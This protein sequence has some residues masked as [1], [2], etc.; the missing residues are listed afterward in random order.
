MTAVRFEP[1]GPLRGALRPPPDKSIS[2]RA[3][4]IGAMAEGPTRITGYLDSAD[5]RATLRAVE[6]L[7]AEVREGEPDDHGG[8]F[9]EI[10]G[11]GL[12][13]AAPGRDRRRQRRDAAAAAARV[14]RRAGRRASGRSTAT[15]RSGAGRSTGSPSRC[16]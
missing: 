2:H 4:L 15:T 12:R 14:A 9:V 8:I 13:G 16:G 3:A 5:T 1:A 10:E 11:V 7:G 6:A